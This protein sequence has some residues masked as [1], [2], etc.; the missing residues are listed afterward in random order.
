[1]SVGATWYPLIGERAGWQCER[2]GA[3]GQSVHHRRKRSQG[4]EWSY[5]N[6]VFLC[7]SGTTG[8]HGWVEHNA[9]AAEFEGYHVRPWQDPAK[10]TVL[11]RDGTWVLLTADGKLDDRTGMAP[12]DGFF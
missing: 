10:V 3:I 7:G 8:C 5:H 2:C 9:N 1:M 12:P 6:L 11:Y 4:G